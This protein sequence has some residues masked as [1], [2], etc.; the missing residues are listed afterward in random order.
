MFCLPDITCILDQGQVIKY[1]CGISWVMYLVYYNYS[2]SGPEC[3]ARDRVNRAR[4]WL[5]VR[6]RRRTSTPIQGRFA[7]ITLDWYQTLK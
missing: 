7:S 1:F 6:I 3:Q 2:N 5:R 4:I